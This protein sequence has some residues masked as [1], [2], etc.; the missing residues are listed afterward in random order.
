[1]DAIEQALN[2]KYKG[3]AISSRH[4][5]QHEEMMLMLV[6]KHYARTSS[7]FGVVILVESKEEDRLSVE[8]WSL[9]GSVS[10][11]FGKGD[12]DS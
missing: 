1:M 9:G 3:H 12:L 5:S 4:Y 10:G 7:D 2:A 6:E 8:T 11:Y